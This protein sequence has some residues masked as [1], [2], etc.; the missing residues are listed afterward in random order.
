MAENK[1]T[2]VKIGFPN[3]KTWLLGLPTG[4]IGYQIHSS[5]FWAIMDVLFW[6][7]AWF[8]WLLLS[9]VNLSIIQEAFNNLLQ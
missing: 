2:T 8:K 6:P 5:V 9:E 3:W 7:F 4:I 1:K